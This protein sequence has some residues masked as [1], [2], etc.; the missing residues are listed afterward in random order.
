LIPPLVKIR[1]WEATFFHTVPLQ[2]LISILD[3]LSAGSASPP[4]GHHRCDLIWILLVWRHL[5][6]CI[7]VARQPSPRDH[8]IIPYKLRDLIIFNHRHFLLPTRKSFLLRL[9]IWMSMNDPI[10]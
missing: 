3:F 9:Q 4:T 8:P 7:L 2:E 6:L 10:C 5:R 1:V